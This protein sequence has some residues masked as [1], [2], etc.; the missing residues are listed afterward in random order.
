MYHLVII[1][2]EKTTSF[3]IRDF[4]FVFAGSFYQSAKRSSE[5]F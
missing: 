3:K 1:L 4:L 2:T 5:H